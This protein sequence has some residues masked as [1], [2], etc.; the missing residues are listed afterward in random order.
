MEAMGYLVGKGI[1][2]GVLGSVLKYGTVGG[3][4]YSA[5]TGDSSSSKSSDSSSNAMAAQINSPL[6]SQ[7]SGD[8]RRLGEISNESSEL[9]K[10]AP[11]AITYGV[12]ADGQTGFMTIAQKQ[13]AL[14]EEK[15]K[16]EARTLALTNSIAE[17]SKKTVEELQKMNGTASPTA[18]KI[19][20][21][22]DNFSPIAAGD[23]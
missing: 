12:G 4:I 20:D 22:V 17:N 10:Y 6:N 8:K 5:L 9:T 19:P 13:F 1:L 3:W 11:D 16:L 7:L 18:A 23:F 2:Q 21:T 14:A 15:K